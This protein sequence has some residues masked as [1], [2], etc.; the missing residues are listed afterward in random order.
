VAG[1]DLSAEAIRHAQERYRGEGLEFHAADCLDL[2]FGDA[3]FDCVVSFETLEHLA[4]Q[5][6]L[7][8]EF[9]RVLKPDGFLVL[10]SP[11]KAVYTDRQQNC[12]EYHVRELYRNELESLLGTVF[13][14][15]RLWGQKLVF[16]SA[17]W[18]LEPRPGTL[19]QQEDQGRVS[20]LKAPG[21]DP[22]YFIALCARDE[23][24]LPD[25]GHGLSLFDDAADS[26]YEHYYHEIRKNMA[27]G[28]LLAARDREI[29]ELK[30]R[31]DGAGA[32]PP[33]WRR[34]FGGR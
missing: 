28:E 29:N 31:L 5:E 17:I 21:H 26:V 13:P 14:A 22:V 7:L 16:Q 20:A 1:V 32:R 19:L 12:N 8:S 4:D 25:A 18:S 3:E 34:L 27:A 15:R 11:D 24:H 6:R 33:W 9:S 10:S 2:P 30:S 23:A